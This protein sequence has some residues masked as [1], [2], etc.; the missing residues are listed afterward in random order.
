MRVCSRC[1]ANRH[2]RFYVGKRGRICLT[3]RKGGSRKA[4]RNRRL[5]DVY[6]LEPSE[7]QAILDLC[8]GKCAGCKQPRSYSL[9]V[10]HDHKVEKEQGTRA[11]IRGPLCKRDN[12][13]LRDAR[14]NPELL[15]ALAA[16]LRNPPAR[17]VLDAVC[18][19]VA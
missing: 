15:E 7:W 16:Y 10:D 1:A 14:D 8:D 11:S 13:I 18:E 4:A 5:K 17:K 6:E 19:T 2:E 12:K 3:C 9:Q